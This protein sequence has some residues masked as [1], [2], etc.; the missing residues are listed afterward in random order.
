MTEN[1][2]S[3][4]SIAL[5]TALLSA[6]PAL[7]QVPAP[8]FER[9]RSATD[10]VEPATPVPP[11][12]R[13]ATAPLRLLDDAPDRHVVVRGDT[14]WDI[15]GKFL[16]TPWRWPELW[17]LNREQIRD[18]HLI[19]PGDIVY[20]DRGGPEPRLRLGR[21]VAGSATAA[22]AGTDRRA[23]AVRAERIADAAIPALPARLLEPFLNRPLV[24]EERA[25]KDDPRVLAAPENRV[26]LSRGDTI[27]ARNL[28]DASVRDWHIW[29]PARPILDPDTRRPIAWEALHVGTARLERDGDPATLRIVSSTQEIGEGD[30]LTAVEPERPT[31]FVPRAPEQAVDGRIVAVHQ[32][33]RQVGRHSVVAIDAGAAQGLEPGHVL[34]VRQAGRLVTGRESPK[35]EQVRLP[36]VEVGHLMVFRVF[37][38]IAYG[39][40]TDAA[41]PLELGDR[42]GQP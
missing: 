19:Y 28:K 10:L 36:D 24:V 11:A 12:A 7:A 31:S 17:R 39:L 9:V 23:P 6:L 16:R 21:P 38:R 14:L 34:A 35:R 13:K 29:R 18:P 30:R 3:M 25:M 40:V 37:D 22:D 15:S 8:A 42:V 20:L 32:G 26:Y 27:Y 41:R 5:A 2:S 4:R 33:V 1:S